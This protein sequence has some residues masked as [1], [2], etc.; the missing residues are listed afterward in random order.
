MQKQLG[1]RMQAKRAAMLA[2]NNINI[3]NKDDE[4]EEE[5]EI[6]IDEDSMDTTNDSN[7]ANSEIISNADKENVKNNKKIFKY[8]NLFFKENLQIDEETRQC[9]SK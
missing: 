8:K 3:L 2:E 4:E 5:E 9:L 7:D 1:I 6:E